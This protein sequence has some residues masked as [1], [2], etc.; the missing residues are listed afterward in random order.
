VATVQHFGPYIGVNL[1]A[2]ATQEWVLGPF[3]KLFEAT[4]EVS[5]HPWPRALGSADDPANPPASAPAE[6]TVT[7]LRSQLAPS[8]ERF[9]VFT[10]ATGT[11]VHID[12]YS[13]RATLTSAGTRRSGTS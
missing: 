3:P 9:L 7:S 11:Q 13:V 1:S 8:G 2:R 6:V 4:A 10:V 5:A 12:G